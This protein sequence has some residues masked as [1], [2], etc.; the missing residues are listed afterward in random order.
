[1]VESPHLYGSETLKNGGSAACGSSMHIGVERHYAGDVCPLKAQPAP[2]GAIQLAFG[3]F[4]AIAAQLPDLH[5][6]AASVLR[7]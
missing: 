5:V 7:G 3:E 6:H 2:V 1:M 4:C